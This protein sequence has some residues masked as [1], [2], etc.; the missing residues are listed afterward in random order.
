MR[1]LSTL[2]EHIHDVLSKL[3][4]ISCVAAMHCSPELPQLY[5]IMVAT[6][7]IDRQA[8]LHGKYCQ[9]VYV[10]VDFLYFFYHISDIL[11]T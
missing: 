11:H 10:D 4:G 1:P 7:Y 6:D 5:V 2:V 9:C 3:T 8:C